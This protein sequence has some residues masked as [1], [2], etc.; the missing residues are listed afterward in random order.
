MAVLTTAL[1]DPEHFERTLCVTREPDEVEAPEYISAATERLTSAGVRVVQLHRRSRW[2]LAAWLPLLKLL[3]REHVDV[4][5]SHKFGANVWGALLGRIAGVTVIVAHEHSWAFEGKPLRRFL[6][7][8]LIARA[9]SMIVAVSRE[10][11]RRMIE[12]EGI[13]P[14]RVAVIPNGI[15]DLSPSTSHDVVIPSDIP[16]GAAVIGA[17]SM[18]R[19]EKGIDNLIRAA[20]LLKPSFPALRVLIA[21]E[22]DRSP[23]EAL[24]HDLALDDTVH[25]LGLRTDVPALL[26]AFQVAVIC[27]DREGSP[28]SVIEYMA[29]ARPIVATRVGGVPDL[30]DDGV[31]GLLVARRDPAALAAAIGSLLRDPEH[32]TEMGRR[33]RERQSRDFTVQATVTRL[34]QLYVRELDRVASFKTDGNRRR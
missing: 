11:R 15:P 33:A 19:P 13:P 25:L 31:E 3:R 24:I 1:L 7:R 34:E 20:A 22:G 12:I 9:S 18:L 14:D 23:I 27:S 16:R 21:G 8:E 6:D 30:I 2:N 5:H 29:A 32:A 26:E 10:D 4:L 17:V 28:L